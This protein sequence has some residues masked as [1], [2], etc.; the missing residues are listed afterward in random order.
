MTARGAGEAGGAHLRLHESAVHH[1][2]ARGFQQAAGHGHALVVGTD[3]Q[4]AHA[5]GERP[6]LRAATGIRIR[7]R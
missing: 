2:A 4:L 5:L 3:F 7:A 6:R 1:D